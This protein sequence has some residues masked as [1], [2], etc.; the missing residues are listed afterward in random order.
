MVL[1]DDLLIRRILVSSDSTS[2]VKDIAKNTGGRNAMVT[3]EINS[4][5]S[6]FEDCQFIHESR[7]RN[8][9]ADSLAKFLLFLDFGRH[10]WLLEPYDPV[11]IPTNLVVE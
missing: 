11:T 2:V 10:V 1:A 6:E 5:R 8:F 3:R 7:R 4:R 9:E